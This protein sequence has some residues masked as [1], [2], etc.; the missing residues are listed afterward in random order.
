[1]DAAARAGRLRSAGSLCAV[2]G[3]AAWFGGAGW[4]GVMGAPALFAALGDHGALPA[5]STLFPSLFGFGVLAG[6][7]AA[8]GSALAGRD[9]LVPLAWSSVQAGAAFLLALAVGPWVAHLAPGSPAF[10]R[11]HGLS[12]VLAAVSWLGAVGGLLSAAGRGSLSLSRERERLG[13]T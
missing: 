2:L 7:A 12:V 6:V 10:V 1:M 8:G 5:V 3:C 4:F 9:G 11:A 13:A